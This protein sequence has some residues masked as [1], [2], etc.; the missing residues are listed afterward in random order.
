MTAE[1]VAVFY[2]RAYPGAKRLAHLLLNG[3]PAADDVVQDAFA[4]LDRE[5]GAVED[6][7]TYLLA[8]LVDGCSRPVRRRPDG[9]LP[10]PADGPVE[11]PD[12]LLDAVGD[13]PLPERAA[14]VL[15]YWSSAS[16]VEIGTAIGVSPA[17]TRTLI[18]RA[19]GHLGDQRE[20]QRDLRDAFTTEARWVPL[21]DPQWRGP[22][23]AA[24]TPTRWRGPLL[25]AAV[26]VLVLG[27]AITRPRPRPEGGTVAELDPPVALVGAD[28]PLRR[29]SPSRLLWAP[30]PYVVGPV[31]PG[32]FRAYQHGNEQFV[33][34]ETIETRPGATVVEVW[35]V[36]ALRVPAACFPT[37]HPRR[38]AGQFSRML[39]WLDLPPGTAYV[40]Y[41]TAGG[42]RWQRAIDGTVAF[43]SSGDP[44]AD[45]VAV[46]AEGRELQRLEDR[47]IIA[48]GTV[49]TGDVADHDSLDDAG[50]RAVDTAATAGALQCLGAAGL[51]TDPRRPTPS[52]AEV[53]AVWRGCVR[54]ARAAAALAFEELGGHVVA[55]PAD[56][57]SIV[58]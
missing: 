50:D 24:P 14:L 25:A 55:N 2:T 52:G 9:P 4:G 15:R 38:P 35:C 23:P 48:V 33:T 28:A 29:I 58:E 27:L 45:L 8:A 11:I 1:D 54:S 13:L 46:D 51:D 12:P 32:S 43:V 56:D 44:D 5:H 26:A 18:R 7:E 19:L 6:P 41:R 22:R 34:Y 21:P 53:D 17:A 40:G 30:S 31:R 49:L 57:P 39:I 42:I 20:L 37:D 16:D 10:G 3:S 47:A 36:E